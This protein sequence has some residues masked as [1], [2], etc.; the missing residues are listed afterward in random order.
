MPL[1]ILGHRG[2]GPTSRNYINEF[3]PLGVIPENSL[4][5]FESALDQGAHGIE[6]DLYLSADNKI[7]ICR[8]DILDRNVDGFH[9]CWGANETS[10]L[11]RIT[12]KNFSELKTTRYGL[13]MNQF[14][15]SLE[16]LFV[17]IEKYSRLHGRRIKI[18]L[19]LQGDNF[20][21]ADNV[22]QLIQEH[23]EKFDS[24]LELSDFVIN[25]FEIKHLIRFRQ[26]QKIR[27]LVGKSAEENIKQV[28]LMLG[29][30][31]APLFG[32]EKLLPGWIPAVLDGTELRLDD[33]KLP[34]LKTE[35]DEQYV[36]S[37]INKA[38][39][40][41]INYLDIVSADLRPNL[42]R[43]CAANG[44]NIAMSCNLVRA[45][46]EYN[47]WCMDAQKDV[48]DASLEQ[49]QLLQIYEYTQQFPGQTFY[50]KADNVLKTLNFL[51][52]LDLMY[53]TVSYMSTNVA[54]LATNHAEV[55]QL[56]AT[57]HLKKLKA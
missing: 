10:Q 11:G 50:Y 47:L 1:I 25:S 16:E 41:N 40:Y 32:N 35:V 38:K 52:A 37:L 26:A 2:M 36:I 43:L 24:N 7:V 13:G 9:S 46:A 20:D 51:H 48:T 19:E 22:W 30:Y 28:E 56:D 21:L 33:H 23:V 18:N 17:L 29:V 5:A 27:P 8:D 53:G 49:I 15:P 39:H 34:I 4:L 45:R 55:I 57:T 42:L 44:M 3:L 12:E 31:T 54:Q 6:L 14:I